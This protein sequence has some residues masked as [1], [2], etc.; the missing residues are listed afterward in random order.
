MHPGIGFD[1]TGLRPDGS[2]FGAE[3]WKPRFDLIRCSNE[4]MGGHLAAGR[5]RGS[6]V[7][8]GAAA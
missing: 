7:V 4:E 8:G 3:T 5:L 2:K 1:A 6:A